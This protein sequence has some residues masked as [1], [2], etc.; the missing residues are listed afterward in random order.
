MKREIPILTV[1]ELMI[2][3]ESILEYHPKAESLEMIYEAWK[4]G[5][6]KALEDMEKKEEPKKSFETGQLVSTE[7]IASACES[8]KEFNKEVSQAL[9]KYM[10]CNWG[11]SEADDKALNDRAVEN[12]EKIVACYETSKGLVFIDTDAERKCTTIMFADEY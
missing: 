2:I 6:K 3:R 1:D 5:Y 9:K 4:L 11:D 10:C 7:G 8:D 12:G